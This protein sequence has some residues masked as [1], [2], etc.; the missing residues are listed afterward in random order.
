M[1]GTPGIKRAFAISSL[2]QSLG[3]LVHDSVGL[4][5]EVVEHK[6]RGDDYDHLEPHSDLARAKPLDVPFVYVHNYDRGQ[7][8]RLVYKVEGCPDGAEQG[9]LV[10][11]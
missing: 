7:D 4:E 8:C 6:R 5:E 10:P 9:S 2:V 11:Q 3:H 1:I